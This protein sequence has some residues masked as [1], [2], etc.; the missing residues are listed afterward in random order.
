M[1]RITILALLPLLFLCGSCKSKKQVLEK[2]DDLIG[3]NKMV[4]LIAESYLIESSVHLAPDTVSRL[5]LTRLYYKELFNRHHVTRDQFVRSIDYYISEENSAEKLL[6]DAS[7]RIAEMRKE[8]G[9][10]D[11][12]PMPINPEAGIPMVP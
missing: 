9:I 6:T 3:R 12:M 11:T 7:N 5:L 2:P 4:E 10:P 8:R 1:K